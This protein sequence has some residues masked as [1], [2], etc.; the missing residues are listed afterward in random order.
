MTCQAD[1]DKPSLRCR[2]HATRVRYHHRAVHAVHYCESACATGYALHEA[3]H[4][5]HLLIPTAWALL[6]AVL[7]QLAT[8]SK[9]GNF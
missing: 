6:V 5:S 7:V 8:F 2:I 1:S 4:F 3:F 9:G